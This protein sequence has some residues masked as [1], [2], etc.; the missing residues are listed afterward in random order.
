MKKE[1]NTA[2]L[3]T[4]FGVWLMFFA[5]ASIDRTATA[6]GSNNILQYKHGAKLLV[7]YLQAKNETIVYHYI[8]ANDRNHKK[9]PL[10]PDLI[11]GGQTI[12]GKHIFELFDMVGFQGRKPVTAPTNTSLSITHAIINRKEWHFPAKAQ[13]IIVADGKSFVVPVHSQ[14]NLKKDDPSDAEFYEVL[15]AK[16]AFD[17]YEKIANAKE[18]KIQIGLA[19]FQLDSE[20]IASYRHFFG[21]ITPGTK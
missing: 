2:T 13:L 19:Y 4:V 9:P 10:R 3:A 7:Q 17:M 6:A 14:I 11:D 18:V 1:S 5:C 20:S 12:K 8:P 15:I 16:P 21:Y